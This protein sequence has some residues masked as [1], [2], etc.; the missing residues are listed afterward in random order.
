MPETELNE[1][2]VGILGFDVK[3]EQMFMYPKCALDNAL[4]G[5]CQTLFN[6]PIRISITFTYA[7]I[8]EW[9]LNEN[10]S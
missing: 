2:I 8:I 3:I 9:M 1:V 7:I 4:R 5:W 10:F 6:Q